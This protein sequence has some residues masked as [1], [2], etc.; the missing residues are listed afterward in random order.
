MS[1]Q[2]LASRGDQ[3]QVEQKQ[4]ARKPTATANALA[5]VESVGSHVGPQTKSVKSPSTVAPGFHLLTG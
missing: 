5:L 4:T 1:A 3:L 2:D